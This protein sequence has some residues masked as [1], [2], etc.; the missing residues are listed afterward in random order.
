MT[1]Q[2]YDNKLIEIES[3][4]NAKKTKL[5]T[6]F[7]YSNNPYEVGDI[8]QTDQGILQIEKIKA[9][10]NWVGKYPSCIYY[11]KQLTSKLLPH[12]KPFINRVYQSRIIKK[13]Q[14]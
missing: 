6:T 11:G 3:E 9:T 13:I 5:A 10:I 1:Q 2:E 12:K 8:L 4:Y 14:P 7:A